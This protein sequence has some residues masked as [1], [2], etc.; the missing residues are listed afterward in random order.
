MGLAQGTHSVLWAQPLVT[1][2]VHV[3]CESWGR[4]NLDCPYLLKTFQ[5]LEL[6]R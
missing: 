4:G 3:A 5:G 6:C 1:V 2:M